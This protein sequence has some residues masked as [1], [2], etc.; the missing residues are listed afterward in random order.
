MKVYVV[1]YGW[2]YEGE[3]EESLR[4]FAREEDAVAY[5]DQWDAEREYPRYDYALMLEREVL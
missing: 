3:D 4:V 5:R 1:S 2:D